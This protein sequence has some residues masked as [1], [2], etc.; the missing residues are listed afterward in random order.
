MILS[1]HPGVADTVTIQQ[2]YKGV[3]PAQ[4]DLIGYWRGL[5]DAAG[6]VRRADVDP[7]EFRSVL[8]STSLVEIESSGDC[9]FR[10]AGSRLRKIFG[11]EARGQL[12]SEIAGR[13]GD[14]YALGLSA[15]L[16][17]AAPVGGV[18]KDEGQLH[19][20]LR[21]PLLGASGQMSQVLCLDELVSG[22]RAML[23]VLAGRDIHPTP[24]S[25]R[26]A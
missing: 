23:D 11:V 25:R 13:H 15:A 20:W 22:R 18:I 14:A 8:A 7:G 3:T 19:A 5:Q 26:A 9:R 16:E 17:R 4:R 21:L 2:A 12:V 10:I 1:N 24:S 6:F